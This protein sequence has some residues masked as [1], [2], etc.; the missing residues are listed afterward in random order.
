MTRWTACFAVLTL[1]SA[2]AVVFATQISR[3]SFVDLQA[4]RQER[5]ELQ[6]RW[7]QLTL[8]Q[9]TLADHGRVAATARKK[10]SMKQPRQTTVV[11]LQR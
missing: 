1:M 10:L 6:V 9:S 3:E 8:E 11:V 5:D 7:E 4:L 2:L